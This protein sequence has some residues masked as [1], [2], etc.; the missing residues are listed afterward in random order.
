M[1]IEKLFLP[2][3]FRRRRCGEG[4]IKNHRRRASM[5]IHAL[6]SYPVCSLIRRHATGCVAHKQARVAG[7]QSQ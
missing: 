3:S 5:P 7:G 6:L 4:K 1:E 2:G